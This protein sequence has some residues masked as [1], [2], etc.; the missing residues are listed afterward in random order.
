MRTWACANTHHPWQNPEDSQRYEVNLV[1]H[2]HLPPYNGVFAYVY[3]LPY[4]LQTVPTSTVREPDCVPCARGRPVS[5]MI[6]RLLGIRRSSDTGNTARPRKSSAKLHNRKKPF[7]LFLFSS[8]K[9]CKIQ[10]DVGFK[11]VQCICGFRRKSLLRLSRK[12]CN[13][14]LFCNMINC[15]SKKMF[16]KEGNEFEISKIKI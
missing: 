3:D 16:L 15:S 10:N 14:K 9:F 4:R 12:Q 11:D 1:D 6:C 2:D 7:H 8:I 5:G 13:L